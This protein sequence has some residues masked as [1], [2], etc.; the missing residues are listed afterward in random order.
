LPRP[1]EFDEET[2]LEAAMRCFWA[3]G[4]AATSMRD[5]GEAMRLGLAS[6]YN[7][8][9]GKRALFTQCLDCYLNANMRARI[10]RLEAAL[11]PGQAIETYLR[12]VVERALENRLGC[13]LVNVALEA[14]RDPEIAGAVAARLAEMEAFFHR[15]A[16]A[17][18]RDGTISTEH[19]PSDIARLMLTTVM[20][21]NV[22]A[23]G[24]PDRALLEGAARLALAALG[25]AK[26]T[27][28]ARLCDAPAPEGVDQTPQP[29]SHQEP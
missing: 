18:Q 9:G 15:C 13:M 21:L 16:A 14:P 19:D 11:P 27:P 23:R 28:A 20:G 29:P 5:L 3:S 26:Q 7:A 4:Y 2:A 12:D 24:R 8:F 22:L 17:G 10:A 6:V 25:P 1:R